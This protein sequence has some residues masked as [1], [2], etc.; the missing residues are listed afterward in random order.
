MG[1]FKEIVVLQLSKKHIILNF[2]LGLF[3][4]F[5]FVLGYINL[6]KESSIVYK[7]IG[8]FLIIYILYFLINSFLKKVIITEEYI[9][10][11]NLFYSKSIFFDKIVG[12]TKYNNYGLI[13]KKRFNNIKIS[14]EYDLEKRIITVDYILSKTPKFDSSDM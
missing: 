3:L 10:E 11:K 1:N 9:K 2:I 13:V 5:I 12:F 4:L 14:H 6:K 7:I 8:V